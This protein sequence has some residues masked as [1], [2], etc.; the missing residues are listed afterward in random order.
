MA[1]LSKSLALTRALPATA[2]ILA[3][4]TVYVMSPR[5]NFMSDYQLTLPSFTRRAEQLFGHKT[6]TSDCGDR[7]DV[8]TYADYVKSCRK[9]G[10]ILEELGI[11]QG[12]RVASFAWNNINHLE[13]WYGVP[14][15][16]RVLH[17][18]NI[19]LFA[20][21]ITYV[22]NH[23]ENEAIF[24]DK[25]LFKLLW[26]LVD[27]F[28]T[29]KHIIVMDDGV[30]GDLPDDPRILNYEELKA[31][32]PEVE[33][34][35]KD[36]RMPASMCYTSGTT[37]MPKAVVYT[38]RSQYLHTMG[39]LSADSL[40][41][42]E[43]DCV[44]PVV[45]MF[46]ANGWGL[47]FATVAV[48]SD[49]V[50]PSRN[51]TPKHLA[52]LME[53]YKVTIAAG[54]PTIWMGVLPELKGRDLSALRGIPVGGSAV[55]LSLSKAYEKATG[56][57]IM[58]AW[59]MTET[60]PL[61]SVCS[62][63]SKHANAPQ[64]TI[65]HLRQSIGYPVVG[66]DMRIANLETGEDLPW[67]GETTGELEVRGPWIASSYYNPDQPADNFKADDWMATGDV[68]AIS[69]DGYVYISDRS[70]DLI[71]SGGEWIG[72]VEVENIIMSHPKVKEA[73]VVAVRSKRWM[74]RPMACVVLADDE[75]LT[76]EELIEFLEPRM[77]K[78]WLPDVTVFVDEIPKTS[79]G[80]FSKK[81]LRKQFEHVV[82]A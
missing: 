22:V 16:S 1:A 29:V 28:K 66:V 75:E 82:V 74:E 5:D 7:V 17:T 11:G 6:V 10:G 48:G 68:A 52:M 57:P 54:V 4:R 20:E 65:D 19:R 25:S 73:A 27:T 23:A 76:H 60:S 59:G 8:T 41:V 50:F 38:H 9:V 56:L 49:L 21:Q 63:S 51:M 67:D 79:V 31:S 40:G 39:I 14:N 45:P 34:D 47:P 71:K 32:V 12:H 81:D 61:G 62:I 72:S 35:V 15:A 53:K 42:R 18:L 46:H 69:E 78:W 55:P 3:R 30:P 33:F 58:Q 80:K 13:L 44:L 24:V 36:E 37:G 70:K 64:E 26:P 77:A 43:T 2:S